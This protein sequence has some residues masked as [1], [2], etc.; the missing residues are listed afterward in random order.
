[1]TKKDLLVKNMECCI[2]NKLYSAILIENENMPRPE[3]IINDWE[4]LDQKIEY[5]DKAYTDDLVLKSC[6]DIKI[7]DFCHASSYEE[8]EVKLLLNWGV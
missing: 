2:S 4:N 8:V 7:K 6:D 1:M 5:I 3:V